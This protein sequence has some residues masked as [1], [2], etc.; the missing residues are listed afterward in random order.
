MR[1][2]LIAF[3]ALVSLGFASV[4]A[5]DLTHIDNEKLQALIADGTPVVDLRRL[6]EW[7]KTGVIDGSHLLTFF[8]KKGNYDA[9][10]WM[11]E[12]SK[13]VNPEKPFVL[14]CQS[15]VRSLAVGKWL[16]EQFNTVY[17]VKDGIVSWIKDGKET[18][19][20]ADGQNSEE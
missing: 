12:L 3:F 18:V 15:G 6:D 4:A 11:G 20:I 9:R 2:T 13:V 17:N 1:N 7:Q 14:I 16:G 10:K 5:A 19:A 8:D